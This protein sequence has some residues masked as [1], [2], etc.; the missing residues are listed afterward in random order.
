MLSDNI[1]LYLMNYI[2][3]AFYL[4]KEISDIPAK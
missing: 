3:S 4:L 2:L 1:V